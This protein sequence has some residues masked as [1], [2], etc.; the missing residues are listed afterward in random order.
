M[1]ADY[2][3][4]G[5]F[6]DRFLIDDDLSDGGVGGYVVLVSRASGGWGYQQ[7]TQGS[8]FTNFVGKVRH[9]ADNITFA[10]LI[11]FTDTTTN[12]HAAERKATATPTVQVGRYLA[13]KGDVTGSVG[14]TPF[15]AFAGFI[16]GA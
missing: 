14:A 13:F 4:G 6:G 9:S 15:K 7:V 16:R 5:A 12:F 1:V 8:G 10:D 11:T 3:G 2:F